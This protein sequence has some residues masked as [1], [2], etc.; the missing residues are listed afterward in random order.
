MNR[1]NEPP[2]EYL[3]QCSPTSLRYFEM[4]KLEHVANLRREL[5]VLLEQMMEESALALFARWM[6]EK[7]VAPRGPSAAAGLSPTGANGNGAKAASARLERRL[8]SDFVAAP[9]RAQSARLA[10][11]GN[12]KSR[13]TENAAEE[14][15]ADAGVDW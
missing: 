10:A 13:P 14:R 12:G 8:L 6:L 3:R 4:S 7:R 1:E 9:T 2:V 5:A 15:A 11:G